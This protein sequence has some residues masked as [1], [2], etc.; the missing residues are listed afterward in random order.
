MANSKA[1][2]EWDLLQTTDFVMEEVI[3]FE[4]ANEAQLRAKVNSFSKGAVLFQNNRRIRWDQVRD[5][6]TYQV[7]GPEQIQSVRAS[8]HY[9]GEHRIIE[10]RNTYDA[11]IQFHAWAGRN[12]AIT[13][14]DTGIEIA[15]MEVKTD[16]SYSLVLK[17]DTQKISLYWDGGFFE[18][19]WRGDDPT[20]W[21][22]LR[23]YVDG[24]RLNLWGPKGWTKPHETTPGTCY[25]VRRGFRL[26]VE[27][28]RGEQRLE[29]EA[30]RK[31]VMQRIKAT[32]GDHEWKLVGP[33]NQ[34]TKKSQLRDGCTF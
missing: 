11:W 25:A 17:N 29:I 1:H 19:P 16:G 9:G 10:Y 18:I 33:R 21:N 7:M 4:K 8:F 24:Y 6:E 3:H 27:I 22:D 5:G 31:N 26:E 12:L 20:F 2:L 15:R 32:F 30:H 14:E 28:V 13:E 34:V 23:D